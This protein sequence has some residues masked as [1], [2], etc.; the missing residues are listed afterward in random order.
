MSLSTLQK[1]INE[2]L[3][4]C[5]DEMVEHR[6][7]FH[8]NPELS[9]QEEK[10]AAFIASYYEKL[11]VPIRTQ[12]GGR[13]VLAYIEGSEPGP[14]VALRADFDALPIQDAKDVPYASTVPGVMHACGHDGH[15]A[16]LLAV[17]KVL[18][19]NR[20]KL[21]GK[22]IIIHQHAEEYAPGGAEPMIADGCLEEADVIFGT[23]LWATEPLGTIL[24]RTGAVM[25]AADRFTINIR[26]KGGHGAHPHDTKD[27]V[28]IGSQI[29]TALQH[30]V[31]RKVN[32]IQ[33]AVISTGSFVASNP[34]NVIADQ[35]T[36][37]GTARSFDENVRSLLEKEIESVVKGVCDMHAASYDYSYERGYPAVVNHPEETDHL[38]SIAKITES[39]EHVIE[40]EPQMGGEDFAYYLQHVKGTF[41]FTGAAPEDPECVHPHH[42]PKFDINE[43]AMLTAAKVLAGA[44]ISYHHS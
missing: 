20:H 2:Q 5:F 35:A 24:Y 37:I 29:V 28:L 38:A 3:D 43:K 10:T 40:A 36:L 42:H 26:G 23:H 41:F 4:S 16:T 30:I 12:V 34:F 39:V 15:T 13:G 19:Q 8:M 11:G 44:A 18:Y 27:A 22:F 32:P 17:A 25:A 31:S 7:F 9:F 21:K 1:S 6:R 14:A 33:S